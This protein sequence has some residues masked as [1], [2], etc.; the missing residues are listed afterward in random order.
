V[1]AA[2]TTPKYKVWVC[3]GSDRRVVLGY[4][5][6]QHGS[7]GIYAGVLQVKEWAASQ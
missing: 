5:V 2:V 4:L 7:S 6:S 3:T 1:P